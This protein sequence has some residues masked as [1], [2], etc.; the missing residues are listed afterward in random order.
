MSEYQREGEMAKKHCS[1]AKPVQGK[2]SDCLNGDFPQSQ[3]LFSDPEHVEKDTERDIAVIP[4]SQDDSV[5]FQDHI[6]CKP[7]Q[8]QRKRKL[9]TI[10]NTDSDESS[11]I[12]PPPRKLT[13]KEIFDNHFR[14]KVKRKKKKKK[15][16]TNPYLRK[17]RGPGEHRNRK[18]FYSISLEERR[19]RLLHRRFP[20]ASKKHT[21]LNQYFKYEQHVLGG[22]LNCVKQVKYEKHFQQSL[23]NIDVNLKSEEL[24]E[25]SL[26][27]RK[28]KYLDEDDPLS[29]ISESGNNEDNDTEPCDAQIVENHTFILNSRIPKKKLWKIK[30]KVSTTDN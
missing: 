30:A 18:P 21:S 7:T 2:S 8:T 14:K 22:F 17:K 16:K 9:P 1:P 15:K 25:E 27:T 6:V 24:E 29:P 3:E 19:R 26:E 5:L 28:F 11:D 13:L 10:Y 12:Q 4:H 23:M 20:F